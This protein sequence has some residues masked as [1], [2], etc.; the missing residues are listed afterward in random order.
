MFC[1][2][3]FVGWKIP[4]KEGQMYVEEEQAVTA[5]YEQ[6]LRLMYEAEYERMA[7]EVPFDGSEE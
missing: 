3:I 5:L 2:K 1:G 7:E 4:R 6:C